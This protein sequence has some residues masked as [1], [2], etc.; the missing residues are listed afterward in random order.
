[1]K[2][3]T[4]V[5]GSIVVS[6]ALFFYFHMLGPTYRLRAKAPYEE[7]AKIARNTRLDENDMHNNLTL[8]I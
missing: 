6:F 5:A 1:M 4:R 8:I 3:L 7:A 2:P